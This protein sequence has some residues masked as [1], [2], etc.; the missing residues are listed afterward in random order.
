MPVHASPLKRQRQSRVRRARNQA[1][2]SRLKALIKKARVAFESKDPNAVQHAV[3]SA[4]SALGKAASKGVIHQNKA[5]RS[6][7]R[8]SRR[9]QQLLPAKASG[10]EASPSAKSAL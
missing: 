2:L 10:E 4:I 5:S 8:L 6:I 3:A 1:I 9:R 7:S